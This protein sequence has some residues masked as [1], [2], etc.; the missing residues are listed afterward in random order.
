LRAWSST[1]TTLQVCKFDEVEADDAAATSRSSVPSGNG[2]G[3]KARTERWP[4]IVAITSFH[5][6]VGTAPSR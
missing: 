2:V 3:K 1:A 4:R 5:S 6:P